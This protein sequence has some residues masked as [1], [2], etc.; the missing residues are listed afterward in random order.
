LLIYFIGG[1]KKSRQ[2]HASINSAYWAGRLIAPLKSLLPAF[3]R[4][5]SMLLNFA[6]V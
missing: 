5:A 3:F 4:P 2:A 6:A 1:G